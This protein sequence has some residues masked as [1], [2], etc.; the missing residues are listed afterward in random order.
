MSNQV[1]TALSALFGV[2]STIVRTD[3]VPN[4]PF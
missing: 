4:M 2:I 1:G 3:M